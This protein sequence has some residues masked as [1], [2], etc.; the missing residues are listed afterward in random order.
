[1]PHKTEIQRPKAPPL[2]NVQVSITQD[3]SVAGPRTL[4]EVQ[5]VLLH[6]PANS[7]TIERR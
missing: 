1:M 4:H 3:R 6:K 7:V 5:Q 2:G